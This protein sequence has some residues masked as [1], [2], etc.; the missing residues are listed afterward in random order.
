MKRILGL[1]LAIA[2]LL[3][4][5]APAL[6][7]NEILAKGGYTI[8]VHLQVPDDPS[9]L[10]GGFTVTIPESIHLQYGAVNNPQDYSISVDPG[11]FA[12][13]RN[14]NIEVGS[15]YYA[16]WEDEGG[17]V[18]EDNYC[19]K[20]VPDEGV[21]GHE[22]WYWI[23]NKYGDKLRPAPHGWEDGPHLFEG[24]HRFVDDINYRGDDDTYRSGSINL[25]MDYS[26]D[27]QA[28]GHYYSSLTFYVDTAWAFNMYDL[29]SE[30]NYKFVVPDDCTYGCG[31]YEA[32]ER[33][34][35]DDNG[36]PYEDR[37]IG[38]EPIGA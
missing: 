2:M 35:F 33:Y 3:T 21:D 7:D 17:N 8:D 34:A 15:E 37:V 28:P 29:A 11:R 36:Y 12:V 18:G 22:F 5:A 20:L 6:A 4:L 24:Y 32:E 27:R 25:V 16:E 19:C 1:V 38:T 23:F 30:L 9:A 26:N 31:P 14:V 13:G 10:V